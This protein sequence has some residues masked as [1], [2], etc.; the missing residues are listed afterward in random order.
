[1]RRAAFALALVVVTG[2]GMTRSLAQTP[3]AP[4]PPDFA[5]TAVQIL[6]DGTEQ[7][8]KI[9]KSDGNMRIEMTANGATSIQIM[10]G[11]DAI[12]YLV[13]PQSR[14]YAEFRDPSVAQAV[15][16][17]S[18]PCP[19]EAE[20]QASGLSCTQVGEGLVSGIITQTWEITA[21]QAPAPMV[22][23]W[24]SGR[25]RALSQSWP[26]GT[27]MTLTFQSMQEV[28]GRQVEYWSSSFQPAGQA[29]IIGGWWFDPELLVVVRED[30]PGGV[31][32]VLKDIRI[33]PLDPALFLPPP[34]F[35]RVDPQPAPAPGA[36]Q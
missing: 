6:P 30:M 25:R 10:R 23:E 14:T 2:P 35:T 11:G 7:V 20:M 12:A 16:G 34:G 24:D 5:A 21:P 9:M 17:A 4:M 15:T 31:T 22:I 18:N 26:E 8:G 32:R 1:M 36:G 19:S 28:E 27:S 29:A 3:A 33:G 13:D